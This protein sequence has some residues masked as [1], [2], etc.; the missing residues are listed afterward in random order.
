M[1]ELTHNKVQ[2]L[3]NKA[4]TNSQQGRNNTQQSGQQTS[5]GTNSQ[6][7]GTKHNK[8]HKNTNK[9]LSVI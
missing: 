2:E 5:A 3:K 8:V 6:Q 4:G 9:F 7:S 1:Q